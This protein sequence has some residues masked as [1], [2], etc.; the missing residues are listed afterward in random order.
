MVSGL[1]FSFTGCNQLFELSVTH[2]NKYYSVKHR[3]KNQTREQKD[4]PISTPTHPVLTAQTTKTV[5]TMMATRMQLK[6]MVPIIH[7]SS[8]SHS[9]LSEEH[10]QA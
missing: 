3:N 1:F 7:P 9:G 4:S 2:T 8:P 6:T 5:A 10:S